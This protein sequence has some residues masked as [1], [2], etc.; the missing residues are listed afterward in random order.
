VLRLRNV[1]AV[2]AAIGWAVL[3]FSGTVVERPLL[4]AGLLV[5]AYT[6]S[7]LG[8]FAVARAQFE[9]H[10]AAKSLCV[11][12][13]ALAALVTWGQVLGSVPVGLV[14]RS[15]P[16]WASFLGLL[17]PFF[18]A[19]IAA[20]AILLVPTALLLRRYH[21]VVPVLTAVMAFCVSGS[22][23][24]SYAEMTFVQNIYLFELAAFATLP[25]MMLHL[26]A[27]KIRTALVQANNSLQ[28]DRER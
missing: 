28:A 11:V 15:A 13:A 18:A 2:L 7:C 14:P 12:A 16:T 9:L 27:P 4:G 23:P 19:V 26:L 10:L 22:W 17:I 8:L 6:L 20:T 3:L 5:A 1:V 24:G 21:W 25:A